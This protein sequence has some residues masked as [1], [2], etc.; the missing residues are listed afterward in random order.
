MA[1]FHGGC[2]TIGWSKIPYQ[3]AYELLSRET[4]QKMSLEKFEESFS[5][6]GHT[7][8]LKLYPAYQPPNTPADIKYYME[9]MSY[10]MKIS[11][12]M[13]NGTK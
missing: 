6:I 3:Y 7:T 8:L 1:G 10:Y 2:G 12:K 9:M 13:V 11:C 5:G 4:R